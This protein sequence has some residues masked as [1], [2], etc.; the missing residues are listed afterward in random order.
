MVPMWPVTGVIR[1]KNGSGSRAGGRRRGNG[2]D[3]VGRPAEHADMADPLVI[4]TDRLAPAFAVRAR[5]GLRRGGHGP[6]RR[7]GAA[8]R[9]PQRPGRLPGRRGPGPGQAAR[10]ATPGSWRPRC[11]PRPTSTTWWP[12]SR[13]PAPGSSTSPSTTGPSPTWS[14][15]GP[16]RPPPGRRAGPGGRDRRGRLLGAQRGQGDARRPPALDGDRRRPGAGARAPGPH[17]SCGRTTSAT[18]ARRSA[19]SSSTWSTSA[20]TTAVAELSVGD[21]NGF[22]QAAR[23][24]LRRRRRLQGPG[25]GAGW[26]PS[27]PAT[28]RRC[29]CGACWSTSPPS[30]SRRST[31]ASACC[32]PRTTWWGRAPTTTPSPSVVA[33][34]D[35]AGPPG[36][37]RRGRVRV[38]ARASPTARATPSR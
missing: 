8:Q 35:A 2:F 23:R 38:P 7:A 11:W 5:R 36:A 20:R 3:R 33:D 18:G 13:W 12:R 14:A 32:S 4:L 15:P 27:R 10:A 17:R 16:R 37:R 25:P 29:A 9:A 19:C 31:T 26:W 6:G 22:Y 1:T 30:T 24:Q 21:L 28:P 34:L